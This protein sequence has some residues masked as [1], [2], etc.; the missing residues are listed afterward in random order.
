[1]ANTYYGIAG[2]VVW[3]LRW[4]HVSGSLERN[5]YHQPRL[6]RE[7]EQVWCQGPRGGVK[8]VKDSSQPLPWTVWAP[9]LRR[10]SEKMKQFVWVKLRA[11]ALK[12]S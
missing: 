10:D 11:R 6:I 4:Q 5:W 8:L 1:V 3:K 9:Y 12:Q 2:D 7:S